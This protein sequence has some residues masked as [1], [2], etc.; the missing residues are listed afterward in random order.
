MKNMNLIVIFSNDM[1]KILMCKRA[2][3]PYKNKYNFVG[4]KI[5][6]ENDGLNEAYRELFEE[7][8]ITKSDTCLTHFM[9]LSYIQHNINLEV[10]YG[11]LEHDIDLIEEVNT[12]EWISSDENFFDMNRFAGEGNVGHIINEIMIYLNEKR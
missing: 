6:K 5:E 10:Y 12:L 11:I 8:G 3:D 2:K 7:T 4:G 1:K 9:N